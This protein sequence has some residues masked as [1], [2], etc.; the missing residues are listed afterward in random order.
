MNCLLCT[1]QFGSEQKL[2][3]HYINFH[4]VDLFNHF[5]QKLDLFEEK[6]ID[7]S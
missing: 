1:Q 2:K 6:P 4:N 3:E 7:I 5:F